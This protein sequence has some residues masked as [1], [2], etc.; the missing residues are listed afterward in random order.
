MQDLYPGG[1][2]SSMFRSTKKRDG[3][4]TTS[5]LLPEEVAP[6]AYSPKVTHVSNYRSA[7]STHRASFQSGSARTDLYAHV[8]RVL[9][10]NPG[11]DRYKPSHALVK[12]RAQNAKKVAESPTLYA[13]KL[14]MQR[15][16]H[17]AVPPPP[18]EPTPGKRSS[19]PRV[20][21]RLFPSL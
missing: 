2:P 16:S 5:A 17:P 15:I 6:G 21:S 11:P 3:P 10:R 8:E 19:R 20:P 12:P 4:V 18:S 1:H 13:H 9:S 14:Y 7:P